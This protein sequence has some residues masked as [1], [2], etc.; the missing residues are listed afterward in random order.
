MPIREIDVD[1]LEVSADTKES[2]K[3]LISMIMS[4]IGIILILMDVI[5]MIVIKNKYGFDS[6]D[7]MYANL[8]FLF[9]GSGVASL[10]LFIVSFVKHKKNMPFIILAILWICYFIY[11]VIC[12]TFG[13]KFY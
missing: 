9:E 4:V 11:F 1:Q 8:S 6:E 2:T 12:M 7:P 10:V 13:F 5:G 3:K